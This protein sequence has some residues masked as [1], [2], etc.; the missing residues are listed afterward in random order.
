MNDTMGALYQYLDEQVRR[1]FAYC[2]IFPRRR[3]LKRDD[4][5]KLW[6]AE[7][8][9]KTSKPEEEMKDVAKNYFDELLSASFL[10]LGGKQMV[11]GR[12]VDY[13]TIHDLLCDLAEEIAGRDCFRIEKD[14][15]GEV[16]EDVRYLFVRTYNRERITEKISKLQNLRTLIID[17]MMK[18]PSNECKVFESI[19]TMFTGLR[20][21]RV[22][23]LRLRLDIFSFPD[24]IG[25]LKHL[26]YF[27]FRVPVITKQT[28]PT[29][30]TKLYHI[31]V[32]DF[33]FCGSLTSSSGEDMMNLVNLRHVISLADL[34][35]P[36]VGR[37]IWLHTLPFF[38]I[39]RERGYEPHQLKHL[40]KLEG[41]LL[42][43]GLENVESKEEA[44]EVNLAGKEKLRKL[45]LK[46]DDDSCSPELQ[47]EV[48]DGLC[49]S[50]YLEI[51]DISRYHG[52]RLP[53]WMMGK[54]NGGPK[55]LQE[56]TFRRW[57]Q[58]G[59]APDLGAFIHLQSLI[60]SNCN[61]NALS[62]NMEHLTSL[63]KLEINSC[64]NIG[65]LP[66]LPKSLERFEVMGCNWDALPG[67]MEHLTALKRLDINSCKN[68]LLLPTLP[69]SL[70]EF[71]VMNCS[72]D[73]LQGNME[74]LTSL[75][76]FVIW[77]CRNMRSLP[78][79][80]KSLDEFKVVRYSFNALPGN[81]EHITSLR[82]LDIQS[83]ENMRLLPTLPKSLEEF[84]VLGCSLD[85]LPGNME[86]LTT[87]KKLTI[88][89]CRNIQ[90]L[91]TLPKSLERLIVADCCSLNALP[92]NMDHLTSLKT[93]I[94]QSC[95]NMRSLPT[96]PKSLEE[97]A[98]CYCSDE[99]MQSCITTDDPNWQKIEHIPKKQTKF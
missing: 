45:V 18:V 37:L 33:G 47:A 54:H 46:W 98:V 4:L 95:K 62:G 77:N 48:L 6:V 71:N 69:K 59:P 53:N 39:R 63:K 81:I 74:H 92:G 21:L 1:C 94:I 12:V 26:R 78:T 86:H 3:R 35:F 89:I 25:Q 8:F 55:N 65:S 23:N 10:Q 73:A 61:W 72:R 83:C 19:F 91:P 15:T 14:F 24:S 58:L 44:L 60:L 85:A 13:F 16:P 5:V 41:K 11:D 28:L 40:N 2:S 50:K 22:L 36:N 42:I 43:N 70:E 66:T 99:F 97:I 96:L 27:A 7:G 49:P 93:L 84:I 9:I 34:K 87:L 79:L 29:V 90:L 76:K 57:I 30:F 20:K 88:T 51:L 38:T 67:N 17:E 52:L 56:L 80:P 32:V 75:K 82:R 68:I 31:R 64:K